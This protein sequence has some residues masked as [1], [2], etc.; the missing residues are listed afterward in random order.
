MK[1]LKRIKLK[2]HYVLFQPLSP[3]PCGVFKLIVCMFDTQITP[4]INAPITAYRD[5][6]DE[7]S[8]S[9]IS[10]ARLSFHTDFRTYVV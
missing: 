10:K 5:G 1:V 4:A 6:M 8:F 7:V 2:L 9:H 3:A